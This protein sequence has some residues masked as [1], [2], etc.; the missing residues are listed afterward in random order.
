[1]SSVPWA[2]LAARRRARATKAL[3]E[4][5]NTHKVAVP[6]C[7]APETKCHAKVAL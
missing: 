2:G 4:A 1:M 5:R 6:G 7:P 3:N